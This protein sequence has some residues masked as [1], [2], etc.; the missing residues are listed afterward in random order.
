MV[1]VCCWMTLCSCCLRAAAL[2]VAAVPLQLGCCMCSVCLL[3]CGVL[4]VWLLLMLSCCVR[5]SCAQLLFGLSCDVLSH[6]A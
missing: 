5:V 6:Y 2:C 1:R 4:C 3:L